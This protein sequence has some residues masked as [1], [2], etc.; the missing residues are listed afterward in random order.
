MLEFQEI[1]VASFS[2]KIAARKTMY[3]SLSMVPSDDFRYLYKLIQSE[4]RAFE[5]STHNK[6]DG[7]FP[8]KSA[9]HTVWINLTTEEFPTLPHFKCVNVLSGFQDHIQLLLYMIHCNLHLWIELCSDRD[10]FKC[11]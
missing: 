4:K 9:G 8:L 5:L 1:N 11:F 7:P 3:F 6:V 10:F 2:L